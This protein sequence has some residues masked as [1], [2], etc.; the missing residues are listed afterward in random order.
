MSIE[1]VPV[2]I[3]VQFEKYVMVPKADFEENYFYPLDYITEEEITYAS[4]HHILTDEEV[5]MLPQD[6]IDNLTKMGAEWEE[7]TEEENEEPYFNEDMG[8]DPYMGCYTD[9]C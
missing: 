4:T 1:C 3:T 2:K 9:D 7:M 6:I 8:F 5:S